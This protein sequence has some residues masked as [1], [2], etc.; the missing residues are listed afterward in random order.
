MTL[1]GAMALGGYRRHRH[2]SPFKALQGRN[3]ARFRRTGQRC[4]VNGVW[5]LA[6]QTV[7]SMKR[8]SRLLL[9]LV[10][11]T[12]SSGTAGVRY[13][14]GRE[15]SWIR[16]SATQADLDRNRSGRRIRRASCPR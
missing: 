6:L 3:G 12:Y 15:S 8:Y 13:T 14:V 7:C 4:K 5:Y 11:L 2:N 10:L 9:S 16:G 1:S